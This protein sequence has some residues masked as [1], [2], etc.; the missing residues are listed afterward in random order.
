MCKYA[1]A[2]PV[3]LPPSYNFGGQ[4]AK[5]DVNGLTNALRAS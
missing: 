3:A 2:L 5:E 1:N 4:R